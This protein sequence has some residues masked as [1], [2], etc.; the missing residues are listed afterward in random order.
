MAV[1]ALLAGAVMIASQAVR[2]SPPKAAI[3]IIER[4]PDPSVVMSQELRSAIE[5]TGKPWRIREKKT[6]MEF[7]LVPPG[8]YM[9]GASSG[10]GEASDDEKPAH[11]VRITKA[12]YLGRYEMT[13]GEW[14]KATEESNP[15]HFKASDR[16]P[17]DSMSW[18]TVDKI[19]RSL[20]CRLPA[21]AEWEYAG[22]AGTTASRYGNP[23]DVA[24]HP[25]NSGG[26]THPVGE[27]PANAL[28]FHD[29]LGN[30]WEWCSDW[31]SSDAYRS[32]AG[33]VADPQGPS[34]GGLRLLR[35]GS[36]DISPRYCRVSDRH[37]NVP[38][39]VYY[40]VGVR[41]AMD[42]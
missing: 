26:K 24:W 36:W 32:C 16:H 42:P 7:L 40:G 5:T 2:S 9:R 39:D 12:F 21:E 3:E 34:S 6:G 20:G 28:G 11:R 35:G 17:V 22:R 8:E 37:G 41:L 19:A 29:M 15:S 14:R 23:D 18:D 30:V 38:A 1:I 25:G 13:Q 33:G 10:D 4:H 27:K 31:Y